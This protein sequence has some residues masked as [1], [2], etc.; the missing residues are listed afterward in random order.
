MHKR[1]PNKGRMPELEVPDDY[2]PP[3]SAAPHVTPNPNEDPHRGLKKVVRLLERSRD[4]LHGMM[5]GQKTFQSDD[6]RVKLVVDIAEA[7]G[8][9]EGY[10]LGEQWKEKYYDQGQTK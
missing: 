9:V 10:M 4:E 8:L 6:P 1:D 7:Q 2:E 5:E 3:P